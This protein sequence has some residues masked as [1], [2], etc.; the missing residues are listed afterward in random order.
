[1]DNPKFTSLVYFTDGEAYTELKPNKNILWV[2]SERSDM[3]N[4]LPGKVIKLEI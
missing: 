3:N 4:E 1:M 2:L